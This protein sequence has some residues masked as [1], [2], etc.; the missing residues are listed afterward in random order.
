[1]ISN[2]YT[3]LQ[4]LNKNSFCSM[5][6]TSK[7]KNFSF[8]KF[9]LNYII[10]S[11]I[12]YIINLQYRIPNLNTHIFRS[13]DMFDSTIPFFS[14]IIPSYQRKKFISV[15]LRSCIEYQNLIK[16]NL[17]IEIICIDDNSTDGTLNEIY[18]IKKNYEKN[19]DLSQH[20]QFTIISNEMHRGALYTRAIGLKTAKGKYIL[21]LDSDDEFVPGIFQRLH[22]LLKH[23][24]DIDLVQFRILICDL[25]E[26][27]NNVTYDQGTKKYM[28]TY[29]LFS[30]IET[31]PNIQKNVIFDKS[32]NETK[33]HII[34]D[35]INKTVDIDYDPHIK[36]AS[37]EKFRQLV[38][39]KQVMWNLPSLLFKRD[40]VQTVFRLNMLER[41]VY[42]Q[43]IS[44]HEDYYI[45]Y[46]IFF[47][48]KNYYF[49][50]EIGYIYYRGTPRVKRKRNL[51][52]ISQSLLKFNYSEKIPKFRI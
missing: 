19:E 30:Y 9:I 22:L 27:K 24:N 33:F 40:L 6:I 11:F 8:N 42:N 51:R 20:I 52:I 7:M 36:H 29:K 1:M 31:F 35:F 21:N 13:I 3:H 14:I 2:R 4:S 45:S 47:F 15:A 17:L 39:N 38:K 50:D 18:S 5:L 28:Y 44:I 43:D 41:E 16:Y 26:S 48:V 49:L 12:F 32:I 10:F 25:I 34:N 37:K 23:R 46:V